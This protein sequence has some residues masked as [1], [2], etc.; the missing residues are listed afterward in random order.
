MEVITIENR[1]YQDLMHKLSQLC[2]HIRFFS[3]A[4][5][6]EEA[7]KAERAKEEAQKSEKK[8]NWIDSNAVCEMLGISTRTLYRMKK[9]RMIGYTRLRGRY[10]Y[11]PLDVEKFVRERFVESD[12]ET[13]SNLLK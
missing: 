10:K 13:S 7:E 12:P 2:E 11:N 5:A 8:E 6:A 9:E 4:R 1:A 3:Q